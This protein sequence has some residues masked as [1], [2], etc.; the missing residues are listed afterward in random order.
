MNTPL[1]I[2]I[3]DFWNR[4]DRKG[5]DECWN[6]RMAVFVKTGYGQCRWQGKVSLAHRIAFSLA[7]GRSPE[8]GLDVRHT[9]HN[10]RCC[11][12]RHLKE[13]T[14]KENEA[15]KVAAGRQAKG[16]RNGKY[17]HPEKRQRGAD[18]GRAKL[19]DADVL[20]IRA[21]YAAGRTHEGLAK[22]FGVGRSEI[23]RICDGT[24]WTHLVQGKV[25]G[26]GVGGKF[27]L[28]LETADRILEEIRQGG[29]SQ[30]KLAEEFGVSQATVSDI[31]LGLWHERW[32][33]RKR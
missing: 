13:G 24:V 3:A 11:N 26:A 28:P 19:T 21:L 22:Q 10:R 8:K 30:S 25:Q 32:R 20:E 29:K 27:C 6:W 2:A 23:K 15:D 33:S 17:T 18:H 12:P 16:L 31:K 1:D 9:C 4:V 7:N 14:R 5:E